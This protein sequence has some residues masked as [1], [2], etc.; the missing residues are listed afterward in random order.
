MQLSRPSAVRFDARRGLSA[1]LAALAI[2]AAPARLAKARRDHVWVQCVES[3]VFLVNW[4]CRGWAESGARAV[5][6]IKGD[7]L[8]LCLRWGRDVF[9]LERGIGCCSSR[10]PAK[11][12][13]QWC[14]HVSS[15]TC[16]VRNGSI[17]GSQGWYSSRTPA[18]P[19]CRAA[20]TLPF[21]ATRIDR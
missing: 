8:T 2:L 6:G 10:A 7:P 17:R 14:V 3:C 16:Y 13:N 9:T 20:K 21:A 1:A 15:G 19:R 4:P 5:E 11:G 12:I 18:S